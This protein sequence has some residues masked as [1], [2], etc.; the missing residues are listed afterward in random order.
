VATV[1]PLSHARHMH[2]TDCFRTNPVTRNMFIAMLPQ[3]HEDGPA[4]YPTVATITLGSHGV[5]N[6]YRHR[7][8]AQGCGTPWRPSALLCF[9]CT[10]QW[11]GLAV[12]TPWPCCATHYE[13]IRSDALGRLTSFYCRVHIEI[14]IP[15]ADE[16]G[17]TDDV[18]FSLCLEKNSLVLVC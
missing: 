6:F 12:P 14:A 7:R 11:P 18:V 5:L 15:Y 16:A 8:D 4:F 2:N 3:P 9:V 10:V 17:A 1:D 13:P